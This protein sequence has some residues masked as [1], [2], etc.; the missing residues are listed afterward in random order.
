MTFTEILKRLRENG[1]A[2]QDAVDI[3]V[4]DIKTEQASR[5]NNDGFAEQLAF[6]FT[7]LGE[8]DA[9]VE[10]EKILEEVEP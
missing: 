10:L 1:R 9:K 5:I 3:L 4:I 6:I 2:A 7:S 8:K